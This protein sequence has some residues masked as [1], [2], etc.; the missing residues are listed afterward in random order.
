MYDWNDLRHFLELSRRGKLSLAARRLD[1]DHTTVARRVAALEAAL[2]T[3]LFDRSPKG[4]RLTE[5]GQRLL[6]LAEA[7]ESQSLALARAV[8]GLDAAPTGAVRLA[9]P[10]AFGS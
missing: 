8:G 7:M 1:V 10:E 3:R 5:S 9:T 6:P 4:Y 2:G